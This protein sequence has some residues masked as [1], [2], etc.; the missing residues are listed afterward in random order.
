[1]EERHGSL[2]NGGLLVHRGGSRRHAPRASPR[3][4]TFREHPW[5]GVPL[6][7][8]EGD[9]AVMLTCQALADGV[10]EANRT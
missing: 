2:L 4:W 8:E 6:A 9:D 5:W 10:Q 1:M 3:R 7:G